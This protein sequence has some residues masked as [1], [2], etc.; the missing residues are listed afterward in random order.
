MFVELDALKIKIFNAYYLILLN[1]L[2]YLVENKQ[3]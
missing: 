1:K 2:N 3:S